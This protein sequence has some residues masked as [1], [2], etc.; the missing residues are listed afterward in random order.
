M[1]D[2]VCTSADMLLTVVS[3]VQNLMQTGKRYRITIAEYD[4]RSLPQNNLYWEWCT[5]MAKHFSRKGGS[6]VKEDM[7][8]LMRHT[9]LGYETKMIGKTKLE[10]Q[11]KSTTKLDKHEMSEYMMKIEAWAADHGCLLP[12]PEDNEYTKY[13]EAQ[14]A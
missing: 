14:A 7:H 4:Q 9:F 5:Q 2:R 1:F 10:P 11:L 3:T 8:D 12:R 13:R 6:F